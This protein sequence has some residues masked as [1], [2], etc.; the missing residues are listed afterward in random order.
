MSK[1]TTPITDRN[2]TDIATRTAKAFINILDWSRI[3]GNSHIT[4]LLLDFLYGSS[5]VFTEL[6]TPVITTIPTVTEINSLLAN[7]ER[8]RIVAALPTI[9]GLSEV[10]DD[11]IEGSSADAPDYVDANLWENVL[12]IVH[13]K[14][15]LSAE[16]VI[17]CGLATVGQ[18]RFYQHQWRQFAG[19][20]GVSGSPVRR[21]RTNQAICNAGLKR[22]NGYRRYD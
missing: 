1:Y 4:K 12:D 15:V 13:S 17:Y 7:I 5:T 8:I 6:T 9:A 20:V 10:K 11:Y 2:N 21:A 16:Y 19:W 18:P 22:N 3:Y 14:V